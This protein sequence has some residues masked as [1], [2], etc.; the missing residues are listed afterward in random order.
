MAGRRTDLRIPP[1]ASVEEAAAI[2]AAIDSHLQQSV[3]DEEPDEQ[4]WH[5]RRWRFT[6]QIESIQ[7]RTVRIPRRAPTSP[8]RA[9]DRTDRF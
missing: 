3:S 7:G 4:G 9:A 2:A 1:G 6:R 5:G 8:W